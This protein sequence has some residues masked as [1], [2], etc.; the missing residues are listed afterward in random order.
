MAR[1]VKSEIAAVDR[2]LPPFRIM[3]L[4]Q[5]RTDSLVSQRVNMWLSASFAMLALLLAA[6]GVYGVISYSVGQ[7]RHEIGLRMALGANQ[8]E[9]FRMVVARGL[10][11]VAS[12]AAVG[13]LVSLWLNRLLTNQLWGVTPADPPTLLLVAATL[14]LTGIIACAVPARR[15]AAVDPIAALRQD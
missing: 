13:V 14:G 3:P 12:G 6:V 1:G 7:R 8:G 5:F 2:T 11:L 10:R 9:V 4:E 15:A